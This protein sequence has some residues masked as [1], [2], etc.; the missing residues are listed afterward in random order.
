MDEN[1]AL[2]L[3][4]LKMSSVKQPTRAESHGTCAEAEF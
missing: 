4:I 2:V 3:E 1:R